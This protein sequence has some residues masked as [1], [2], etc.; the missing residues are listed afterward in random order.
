MSNTHSSDANHQQ[1]LLPI[2][3]VIDSH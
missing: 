2:S 1:T 3:A